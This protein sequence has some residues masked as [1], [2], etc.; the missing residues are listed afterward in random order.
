V[1]KPLLDDI[2]TI[3]L[4]RGIF[5]PTAEIYGGLGG[6]YDFGPVGA[7]LRN[8]LI[9]LWRRYF[10]ERR[11]LVL[12]V[13]G[14]TILPAEVFK[15][16]G[17]LDHFTDPSA[18]CPR[19]HVARIDQLIEE[20]LK[21]PAEGKSI[22]ELNQILQSHKLR[23]P[24]CGEPLSEV[25]NFGL[26]FSTQVGGE[27]RPAYLRPE[28]A[29]NVFLG[30]KRVQTAMRAKLPFGIAQIGHSYRNEISPRQ[31][32]VR[33]REFGQMEIEYFI[34]PDALNECP[35]YSELQDQELRIV[36]REAQQAAAERSSTEYDSLLL[37]VAKAYEQGIV[38]NQWMACVLGD[39]MRFFGLL[40]IPKEAIRFR[41]MR[42][43]ETPHY[44]GGNFDLEVQ[45]SI[46]W[47][48]VIGNAYRRDHD[49]RA[50]MNS[51][52]KDLSYDLEGTK[53][54]PHVIEPSF[55]IDRILYCILEHT[56]HPKDE[57][58]DWTWFAFPPLLAPFDAVI[59]PLLN[60]PELEEKAHDLYTRCK[61]KGLG[62]LYD[63]SGHIGRR[64][65]RSDEI[66]IPAAIT[67]DHQ[68]LEDQTV[69]LRSRDTTEQTRHSAQEIPDL[70][71]ALKSQSL[72]C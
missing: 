30:F 70:L 63:D 32:V 66:G 61:A 47:K 7:R 49:L 25:K 42:P 15:A 72:S 1:P 10:I 59:L 50:H 33:V 27:R 57:A 9:Q 69:T 17:H 44:S 62:V 22:D 65:A 2:I 8:N 31:A 41:H 6:F 26:M 12:E 23:C 19:G 24:T 48:E 38:P 13:S 43:E 53:I 3:S 71:L 58:R 40:G 21:I 37:T 18:E 67:I 20:R 16:S 39:E 14:T 51:S 29:Q 55:G 35:L 60:K 4:R 11:D 5:Y 34:N 45:L 64:Y 54:I 46:G 52:Q 36:T 56:Y 68:T 28:T